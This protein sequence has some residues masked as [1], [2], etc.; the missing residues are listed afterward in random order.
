MRVMKRL[1]TI[2]AVVLLSALLAHG[3]ALRVTYVAKY[4]TGSKDLFAEV[5]LSEEFRASLVNA[6]R[7]V[8]ICYTLLYKDGVSEFRVTPTDKPL[9]ITFMG[10]TMDLGASLKEQAK[11]YTYKNHKEGIVIDKKNF[12]GKNFLVTSGIGAEEFKVQEG[13]KKYIL[14][15]ECHLAV[16]KDGKTKVWYTPYIPISNEPISTGLQGLA[17]EIDNGQQIFTA[18][19]IDDKVEGVPVRPDKGTEMT[20]E[21]FEKMV[22][23][24]VEMMKRGQPGL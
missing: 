8:E 4:N 23:E 1:V 19:E 13:E 11:D 22:Q 9:S 20:K 17:L 18:I 2:V 5:G 3:Q 16:S 15:F 6:Y 14:E 10:Q 21:A 12:F 24:R 7:D